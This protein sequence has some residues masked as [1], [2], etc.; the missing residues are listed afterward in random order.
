MKCAINLARYDDIQGMIAYKNKNIMNFNYVFFF[1][2]AD[3][4]KIMFKD[5]SH[6]NNVGFCGNLSINN[7]IL[8]F[9]KRV[10]CSSKLNSF[11]NLPIKELWNK[12]YFQNTFG[13]NN[14]I[15]FV[16]HGAFFRLIDVNYFAYLRSMYPDCICIMLFTDTVNSYYKCFN[17]DFGRRFDIG[18][19]KNTFDFVLSY[20]EVDARKYG[21]IY[22]PL[23]YSKIEMHDNIQDIDVFFIGRA[24]DR[25]NLIHKA[26]HELTDIGLKCKFFVSGVSKEEQIY[27]DILYNVELSYMEVLQ[28]V[29]RSRGILELCQSGTCGFTLRCLE[30]LIYNK[31]LITDNKI[32]DEV[33]TLKWAK[34]PKIIQYK[35]DISFSKDEYYHAAAER[36]TYKGEYSPKKLLEFLAMLVKDKHE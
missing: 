36:Y 28:Y 18:L 13:N 35:G 6:M 8:Q 11:I 32:F 27:E 31:N 10:H 14:R 25:L 15:I 29:N 30:A 9:I 3:Y 33:Q 21:L 7:K 2:I 24:K 26:Y 5:I 17:G 19:V 34:S 1:D 12:Y 16:F 20:N 23:W 22:Y 4:Y